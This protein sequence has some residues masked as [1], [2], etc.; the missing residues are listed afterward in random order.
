MQYAKTFSYSFNSSHNATLYERCTSVFAEPTRGKITDGLYGRA[1]DSVFIAQPRPQSP[2]WDGCRD[3]YDGRSDLPA[4]LQYV[5]PLPRYLHR[6]VFH[7]P[8]S[9]IIMYGGMAYNEPQAK[10]LSDTW[11]S[12]VKS[13]MWYYN[14]FHC[15]NNCS[16]HG[17]CFYGFCKCHVGYYGSDC[18]NT[19]CPGTFCYYDETTNK[20]ICTH[21]C[22]AGYTH[23]DLDTYVQDIYKIPCT[24]KNAGE[25]N[26]ICDGY[27][28]TMCAPPFLG[29]DCGTKD[30]RDNCSFN[31]WCAIEYP[32]SR[33]QCIPGYFGATCA[34]KLCLNNCSYPNGNCNSTAGS[35]NC[36]M[37]YSPYNNTREYKPWGGE[38][39]SYLFPY[40]A[41]SNAAGPTS[42]LWL[43]VA[44]VALQLL[45][46]SGP[47]PWSGCVGHHRRIISG[48][49][50]ADIRPGWTDPLHACAL[51]A[52]D[53]EDLDTEDGDVN[54]V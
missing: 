7:E 38:D 49:V 36:N 18:S 33:C 43:L 29:D 45:L 6:A 52:A 20:Q 54:T 28:K 37:M 21:A 14:L 23:T 8:T 34:E 27:G 42:L 46:A 3:R 19:S 40:S 35:C 32:V 16:S 51:D 4:G 53:A 48:A 9:E 30:C 25:S 50:A 12:D 26:G 31:G 24:Q 47:G 1:N 11:Q 5:Q 15:A 17:D 13:D 39:C 2:G 41:G 10:S 22:Q 44:F